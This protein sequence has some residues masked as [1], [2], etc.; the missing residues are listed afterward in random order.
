MLDYARLTGYKKKSKAKISVV[1]VKVYFSNFDSPSMPPP[2]GFS[3]L[4]AG[5]QL[6]DQYLK[7]NKLELLKAIC[8]AHNKLIFMQKKLLPGRE[9]CEPVEARRA[10]TLLLLQARNFP[11][12]CWLLAWECIGTYENLNKNKSFVPSLM[13]FW[14]LLS[15]KQVHAVH[16]KISPDPYDFRIT[17]AKKH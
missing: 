15:F 2:N 13:V 7:L 6:V 5:M 14:K 8:Q 11:D 17:R 4:N 12:R 10:G 3:T 9:H 1:T 16:N